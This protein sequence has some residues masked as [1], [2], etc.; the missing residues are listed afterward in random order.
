MG[1]PRREQLQKRLQAYGKEYARIKARIRQVGFICE[2]SL[3]KRWTQ[4]GKPTCRCRSDPKQRHGP[5]F[6]LS[7]KEK[8]K[9]VVRRLTHEHAHLYQQWIENRRLLQSVIDEMHATS[10]Q[11][12]QCMLAES[13]PDTRQAGR[14]GLP[15]QRARKAP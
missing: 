12:G 6:Q 14:K 13:R 1:K 5:Y 4:C 2:G 11:A 7:W 3:V 10:R 15:A 9:T 8:G